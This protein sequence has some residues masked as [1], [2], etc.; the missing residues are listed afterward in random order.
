[1][2]FLHILLSLICIL[3]QLVALPIPFLNEFSWKASE[4]SFFLLNWK[5][6]FHKHKIINHFFNAQ[7]TSAPSSHGPPL[8][9]VV[10][11]HHKDNKVLRV[12]KKEFGSIYRVNRNRFLKLTP[13]ERL[14]R[15]CVWLNVFQEK[16]PQTVGSCQSVS[17]LRFFR[18]RVSENNSW[19]LY[20]FIVT[21]IFLTIKMKHILYTLNF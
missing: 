1:M 3:N 9:E 13:Y 8:S 21:V 6:N 15:K 18:R 12:L 2:S 7:H 16:Y 10:V 20:I 4:Y 5:F 19:I 14:A 17:L 11:L